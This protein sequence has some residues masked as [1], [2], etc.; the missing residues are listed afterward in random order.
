MQIVISSENRCP[1][2]RSKGKHRIEASLA[3]VHGDILRCLLDAS[4]LRSRSACLAY[5]SRMATAAERYVYASSSLKANETLFSRFGCC[6]ELLHQLP[7]H[8]GHVQTR[9]IQSYLKKI[10]QQTVC[11]ASRSPVNGFVY[12]L[13]SPKGSESSGGSKAFC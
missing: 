5:L 3:F 7:S 8:L 10:S 1:S 6:D 13:A 11:C 9:A 2:C 12:A 4:T